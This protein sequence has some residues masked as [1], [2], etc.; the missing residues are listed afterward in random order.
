MC[1]SRRKIY[2]SNKED[3]EIMGGNKINLMIIAGLIF[4]VL[5]VLGLGFIFLEWS[6]NDLV[7]VAPL[8]PLF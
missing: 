1:W 3:G 5:M 2:F 7:N 4:L 6:R 8:R